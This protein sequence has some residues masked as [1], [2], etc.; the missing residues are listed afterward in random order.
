[1][2]FARSYML[3][4]IGV[5]LLAFSAFLGMIMPFFIIMMFS[6]I[7][8]I[9]VILS[10]V[11]VHMRA[12]ES[13]LVYLLEDPKK[14]QVHWAYVYGDRDIR[15]TPAM[16]QLEK[17]SY[18]KQ[19][20][21]QIHDFQTYNLAGHK[22]RIVPEGVGHSVSLGKCLYATHAKRVWNVKSLRELRNYIS[23]NKEEPP[24]EKIETIE[25]YKKLKEEGEK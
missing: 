9:M 3:M 7:G 8:I 19:L 5:I 22:L 17:H 24:V 21:Q 10:L 2:L 13:T 4:L 25:N 23:K 16:R 6:I 1:M 11:F 15:I 14:G 12:V 20:D 18:S